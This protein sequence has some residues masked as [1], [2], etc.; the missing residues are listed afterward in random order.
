MDS[1][2]SKLGPDLENLWLIRPS[3]AVKMHSA[4]LL[5]VVFLRVRALRPF[6]RSS[7]LLLTFA[8]SQSGRRLHRFQLLMRPDYIRS[9]I[10]Y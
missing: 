8:A 7:L 10:H 4:L 2:A 5:K 6:A 3:E 9:F 1:G